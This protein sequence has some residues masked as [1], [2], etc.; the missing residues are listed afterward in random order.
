MP[1]KISGIFSIILA[2]C[3]IFFTAGCS[4]QEEEQYKTNEPDLTTREGTAKAVIYAAMHNKPELFWNCLSPNTQKILKQSAKGDLEKFKKDFFAKFNKDFQRLMSKHQFNQKKIMAEMFNGKLYPVKK[5]E[6]LWYLDL[7]GS[8]V[9]RKSR[10][11]VYKSLANHSSKAALGDN[12]LSGVLS[13]NYDLV[14][15]CLSYE[16]Q[17]KLRKAE[18]NKGLDL[19]DIKKNFVNEH[20][21][22][23]EKLLEKYQFDAEKAKAE[24]LKKAPIIQVRGKWYYHPKKI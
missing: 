22:E 11:S 13:S 14:W 6:N 1:R 5:I 20:K 21:P 10:G 18:K 19:Y 23:I 2:A 4:D 17:E 9:K 15:D 24:F 12:F 3:M 16:M 7:E 8:L